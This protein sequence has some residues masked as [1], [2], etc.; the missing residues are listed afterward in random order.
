MHGDKAAAIPALAFL[1]LTNDACCM[2]EPCHMHGHFDCPGLLLLYHASRS[3][4]GG[5][6]VFDR[7]GGSESRAALLSSHLT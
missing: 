4:P 3:A 5:G 2:I 1:L 7:P 6:E